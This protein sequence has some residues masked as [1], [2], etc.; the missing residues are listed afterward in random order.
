MSSSARTATTPDGSARTIKTRRG[1]AS[2][3][4]LVEVLARLVRSV[5]RAPHRKCLTT[6]S[7][8]SRLRSPKSWRALDNPSRPISRRA[9][10]RPAEGRGRALQEM[11]ALRRL[12]RLPRPWKRARSR[13]AAAASGRGQ[14]AVENFRMERWSMNR[15]C[16]DVVQ[17]HASLA[18]KYRRAYGTS[19]SFCD[20]R[21]VRCRLDNIWEW[22]GMALN[23]HARYVGHDPRDPKGRAS[24]H[25]SYSREARRTPQGHPPRRQ[26]DHEYRR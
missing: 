7:R 18:D 8:T 5:T 12:D 13:G 24:R 20:L 11:R 16:C 19:G 4:V 21:F 10:Q 1:K 3:R 17:K 6:L 26:R 22:L 9:G 25:S 14:A 2:G 23:S 15:V